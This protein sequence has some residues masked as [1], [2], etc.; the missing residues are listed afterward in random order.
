MDWL[1]NIIQILP[2]ET[3]SEYLSDLIIWW[4]HFVADV[5][6]EQLPLYAYV[7]FSVVVLLLW[8]LVA[9]MLPRPLGGMSWLA[10]CAVLL[11][12]SMALGDA[13]EIAPASIGVVYGVLM[14]DTAAAL[15]HLLPILVV[16]SVGLFLGFIWSLIRGLVVSNLNKARQ[17]AAKDERAQMQLSTGNYIDP[18]AD[19]ILE[20]AEQSLTK[21]P[22][23]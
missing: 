21:K 8:L 7:G 10:L 16:F 4:S 17:Q 15:A 11:T 14:K 19:H 5:P 12:P 3:I 13:G 1:D 20:D 23:K 9:R 2:L 22:K 6:P 18:T